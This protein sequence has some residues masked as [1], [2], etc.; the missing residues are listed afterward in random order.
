MKIIECGAGTAAA[1]TAHGSSGAGAVGLHA[2]DGPVSVNLMHLAAG[3]R[4]GRHPAPVP[5]ALVVVGGRGWVS[6]ADGAPVGITAGQ[7]AC[8]EPGEE[9][10]TWT[11]GGLTA[12]V[13][14]AASAPRRGLLALP[15]AGAEAGAETG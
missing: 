4:L 13:V 9:H 2:G 15:E 3:G 10:E 6:G 14:E 1:V 8:W 11:D 5:Q 12:V 7:A